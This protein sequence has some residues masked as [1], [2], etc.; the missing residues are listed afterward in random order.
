MQVTTFSLHAFGPAWPCSRILR[1]GLDLA[2]RILC[3]APF[4]LLALMMANHWRAP[5]PHAARAAHQLALR[6]LALSQ[7]AIVLFYLTLWLIILI[8]P[9][10]VGRA[11]RTM[12][13]VMALAGTTMPWLIGLL[14]RQDLSDSGYAI[15][16]TL[17]LCGNALTLYVI[18]HLGRCFSV[19][20]QAR[21]LVTGGP[22][23][24]I[25]HP[26]YLAE[27]IMVVGSALF[28]WTP[29]SV[30]LVAVHSLIQVRRMIYEEQVL[31]SAFPGYDEYARRTRRVL[32]WI[33]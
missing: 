1:H 31:R 5:E 9:K 16:V 27:E 15:A 2:G 11:N 17:I 28:Y 6:P 23:A 30:T 26:L 10:P 21:R 8:R 14:P 22:Y 25:R 4:L 33:W 20:P 13:N 29:M 7:A 18:C 24:L 3:S 12:P 19:V 32:P